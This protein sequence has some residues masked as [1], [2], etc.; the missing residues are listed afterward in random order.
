MKKFFY[1]MVMVCTLGFFAACSS[2]DDPTI[3]DTYKGGEVEL[4]GTSSS[5]G[6]VTENGIIVDSANIINYLDDVKLNISRVDD[7]KAKVIINTKHQTYTVSD[8]YIAQEGSNVVITGT[9][10]RNEFPEEKI[11]NIKVVYNS[12]DKKTTFSLWRDEYKDRPFTA[13]SEK[14]AYPELLTVW[15]MLPTKM[16]D[17]NGTEVKNPDDASVWK[18]AF[19][20]NWEVTENCPDVLGFMKADVAATTA[21][22]LVNKILPKYLSHVAFTSDGK[23]L[24]RYMKDDGSQFVAWDYATYKM[25]SKELMKVYLNSDKILE[26]TKDETAKA[27]LKTI[28]DIFKD[29]IPVNIRWSNENK[30]AYFFLDKEFAAQLA[31]NTVLTGLVKNLGD[32]DLGGFAPMI[33]AIVEQMPELMQNT[34]K[35]EAGVEFEIAND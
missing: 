22:S 19:V 18:G 34:T 24:A 17:A 15:E 25:E 4:W 35:F 5:Q 8:A 23:I 13:T 10:I 7:S 29:G 20:M 30:N 16:Y 28:L 27:T 1:L 9:G 26:E 14:P 32:D 3:W 21:N 6:L 12:E 2:D 31:S 33:K 11:W